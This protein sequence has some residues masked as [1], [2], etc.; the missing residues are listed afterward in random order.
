ME[1]MRIPLSLTIVPWAAF[2][3]CAPSAGSDP[4]KTDAAAIDD[5]PSTSTG[6]TDATPVGG[7]VPYDRTNWTVAYGHI[8]ADSTKNWNR[9]ANYILRPDGTVVATRW[10]WHQNDDH[11]KLPI[12]TVG[13]C[14]V[15][16]A[17]GFG[18]PA[19]FAVPDHGTYTWDGTFLTVR[20]QSSGNRETWK[21]SNPSSDVSRLDYTSSNFAVTHGWG[22]GS[23]AA[24]STFATIAQLAQPQYSKVYFGDYVSH[25][26]GSVG[27]GTHKGFGF[28]SFTQANANVLESY[29]ATTACACPPA[30]NYITYYVHSDNDGRAN[31]FEHWCKCLST[32]NCYDGGAH[33]KPQFQVIGDTGT[34][35]GWIGAEVSSS[36]FAI[37]HY[38]DL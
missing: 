25:A 4:D 34:F 13:A 8:E 31:H 26:H 28:E 30:T 19:G 10:Q 17:Y 38:T 7:L 20:W 3:A 9:L 6:E 22:F 18:R 15:Y 1:R 23:K 37:M 5:A 27:T 12:G 29:Y 32:T 14:T 35:H 21:V 33:T 16:T 24:F 2:A 11:G 36:F